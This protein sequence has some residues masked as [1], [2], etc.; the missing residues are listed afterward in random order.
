MPTAL[1]RRYALAFFQQAV[2]DLA[3][4]ETLFAAPGDHWAGTVKASQAAAEKALKAALF[5]RRGRGNFTLNHWPS[6]QLQ[7]GRFGSRLRA[8][9]VALENLAPWQAVDRRNPEYPSG[10][11]PLSTNVVA[12]VAS[13][14]QAE[15]ATAVESARRVIQWVRR[16]YKT[17]A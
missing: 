13:F 6:Q 2:H 1:D 9:M 10:D 12:P 7:A 15:A 8:R 17:L 11:P 5:L 3:D 4:A 16:V 14:T